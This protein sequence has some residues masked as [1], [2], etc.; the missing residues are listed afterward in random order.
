MIGKKTYYMASLET[1]GNTGAGVSASVLDVLVCMVLRVAENGV[2]SRLHKAP[3]TGVE[4][5]LLGPDDLLQIRVFVKFVT[6]LC[7]REGVQ[8][9]NTNDGDIVDFVGFTVLAESSVNLTCA[10]Q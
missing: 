4:W 7:P 6:E 1:S 2:Q 5:L 3:A 9:L 10:D 8:L